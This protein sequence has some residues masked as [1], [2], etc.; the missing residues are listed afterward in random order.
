MAP[1]LARQMLIAEGISMDSRGRRQ[2]QRD[3]VLPLAGDR[4]RVTPI[5]QTACLL[6][7]V[8]EYGVPFRG[9]GVAAERAVMRR[10]ADATL[11]SLLREWA[12][13]AINGSTTS[14]SAYPSRS[15]TT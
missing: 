11:Q 5:D 4:A 7:M 15:V 14:L 12:A 10:V 9:V 8:A 1:R 6:S 3:V 13:R 2:L